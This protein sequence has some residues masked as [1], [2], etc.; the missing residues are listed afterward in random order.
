MT[1]PRLL[2]ETI[3][4]DGKERID[5]FLG[6]HEGPGLTDETTHVSEGHVDGLKCTRRMATYCDVSGLGIE[7]PTVVAPLCA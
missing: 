1:N 6:R 5:D 4:S 2:P 7:R 3:S